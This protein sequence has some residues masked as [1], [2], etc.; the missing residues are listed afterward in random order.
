MDTGDN[1]NR[2]LLVYFSLCAMQPIKQ[3]AYL[4]IRQGNR[5]TDVF[6]LENDQSL[7]VGR[8]SSNEIPVADERASRRHA[9]ILPCL[10]PGP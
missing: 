1:P 5:W 4:I 6:R 9:E 2:S 7:V 10:N 3:P 8:A